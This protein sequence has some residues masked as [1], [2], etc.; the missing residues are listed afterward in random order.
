MKSKISAVLPLA[1]LA[2]CGGGGGGDL[3]E[4]PPAPVSEMPDRMPPPVRDDGTP[5]LVTD[6]APPPS[7]GPQGSSQL[8]PG[9]DRYDRV[10]YAG[11]AGAGAG[12]FALSGVLPVNSF[13]E[14]TA[15]DTG[16]TM[17]I[18]IRGQG[19][20]L[21]E[22]SGAA[23]RQLGVTGNP[24]VRVRRTSVTPQD[25]ALLSAGQ[26]A[27]M[28]ADAPQALL[29]GLRKKLGQRG[30]DRSPE[31]TAPPV[32]TPPRIASPRP[33]TLTPPSRATRGLFVQVAAVS[34]AQRA[35]TLAD[36]IGGIVRPGGG[37]Y[38][39]QLG[40]FPNNAAAQRARADIAR[41]GY[42][43]ARVISVP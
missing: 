34:S 24:A 37:V 14:V 13:A 16:K 28:R 40:P 20:G 41:R 36:E 35:R 21:I 2:A 15:L 30:A 43:D 29:V 9:E 11:Y 8:R 31:D 33:T 1:L 17:L 23:A 39:V 25:S 10:G 19:R 5:P 32:R 18:Q 22:L 26:A 38:R 42:A 6:G 27:P 4:L 7:Q 12:V 3:Q